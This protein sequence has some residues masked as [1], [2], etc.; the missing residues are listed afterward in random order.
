MIVQIQEHPID[1]PWSAVVH[2]VDELQKVIEIKL[3]HELKYPC[4]D[5][6]HDLQEIDELIRTRRHDVHMAAAMAMADDLKSRR[7]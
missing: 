1:A 4:D 2:A 7:L 5:Y 6:C 3:R